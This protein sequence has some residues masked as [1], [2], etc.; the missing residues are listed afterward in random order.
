MKLVANICEHP[1]GCIKPKDFKKYTKKNDEVTIHYRKYCKPHCNRL[2]H[3][4]D[5]GT[6]NIKDKSKSG[7]GNV[8]AKGYRKHYN[9]THPLAN[10]NG[11]VL[12][13]R[14]VLYSELG[15][16]RQNCHW[17]NDSLKWNVD[18]TV[19]HIDFDKL[20]NDKDNL[21]AS[22]QSCNSR[23]FNALIRYIVGN[24]L[25]DLEVLKCLN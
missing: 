13:H 12:E 15:S 8:T 6:A 17:C 5:L 11:T 19:D 10:K 24:K 4:K 23:R 20:N 21:V 7:L 22:C 25:V 18:L 9:P 3:N 16:G 1:D 14:A 2:A